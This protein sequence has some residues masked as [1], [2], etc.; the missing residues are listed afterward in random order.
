MN[1]N[2]VF[3]LYLS[4]SPSRRSRHFI[5][6]IF[7]FETKVASATQRIFILIYLKANYWPNAPLS[8][9]NG[10]IFLHEDKTTI[11]VRKGTNTLLPSNPQT[12]SVPSIIPGMSFVVKRASLKSCV[13][14]SCCVSLVFF[15]LNLLLGLYLIFM[16]LTRLTITGQISCRVCSD[17]FVGS[18]CWS[19]IFARNIIEVKLC[20]SCRIPPGCEFFRFV[21][22]PMRFPLII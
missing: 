15:S 10:H 22:L 1:G 9:S 12:P 5:I 6:I 2:F 13:A 7:Y 14:F 18:Y 21:S 4:L 16:T 8:P 17:G 11:K 20:L 3:T 19:C